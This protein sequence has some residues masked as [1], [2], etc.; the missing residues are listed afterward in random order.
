MNP[1]S[2]YLNLA[3][4]RTKE[5]QNHYKTDNTE[6]ESL[7]ARSHREPTKIIQRRN[8]SD[9]V[10]SENRNQASSPETETVGVIK[11]VESGRVQYLL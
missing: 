8:Y 11:T 10:S 4:S 1:M 6:P 2:L 5:H 7:K 9:S 3:P